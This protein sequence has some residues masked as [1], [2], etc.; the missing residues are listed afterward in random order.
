MTINRVSNKDFTF[1]RWINLRLEEEHK[2][3]LTHLVESLDPEDLLRWLS[4]MCFQGYSFSAAW[5]DYSDAQQVS[6]VCKNADDPN[7]GLG[8]SA[9]HPDFDVALFTLRY[10]S[11]E[12][13]R[14]NW[15]SAP[16]TP[17]AS[18]WG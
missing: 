17:S 11:E 7:F 10:K 16:P 1:D 3:E 18:A 13:L 2:S 9:R 14:S 4:G 8:L 6:L 15:G 12:I 5:D